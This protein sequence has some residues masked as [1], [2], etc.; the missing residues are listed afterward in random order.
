RAGDPAV[1]IAD[2]SSAQK[3]LG[4]KPALNLEDIVKTAW[5]WHSTHPDGYGA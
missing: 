1:L 2:S 3:V 5:Q 4:W